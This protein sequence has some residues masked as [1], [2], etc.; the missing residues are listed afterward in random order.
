MFAKSD[1]NWKIQVLRGE[2]VTRKLALTMCLKLGK[3]K[4]SN[5]GL[6]RVFY[7]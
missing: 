3:K 4:E 7:V 1:E 2:Q 6:W 5:V